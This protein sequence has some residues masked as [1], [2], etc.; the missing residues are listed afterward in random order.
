MRLSCE[1]YK[2]PRAEQK[3]D[4]VPL[5]DVII[6]F[7]NTPIGYVRQ[8]IESVR[9]QTLQ[10]WRAVV[11]NDG[12]DAKSTEALD[13]LVRGL[14]DARV[15]VVTSENRGL[16]AARNLGIESSDSDFIAFLDS[17]DLW[18]PD[19]LRIQFDAMRDH[20]DVDLVHASCDRL[21]GDGQCNIRQVPARDTGLNELTQREACARM[22]RGNFVSGNTVMVRRSAGGEIGFF[23]ATFRSLEDKEMW[24]RWLIAG[25]RFLHLP[26][27]LAVYRIH[28]TNMSKNALHMRQGRMRLVH[29]I[30]TLLG[31]SSASPLAHWPRL[32]REM[33][34]RAN[35]ET[36][37]AYLDSR[38]YVQA[39]RYAMPWHS[40]LSMHSARL[41][42]LAVLG[43]LRIRRSA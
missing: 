11:V 41:V 39:L 12:S 19:K 5:V 17:D 29:K 3:E 4:I 24:S 13:A 6:P 16:S 9:A 14:R 31:G 27:P 8:A 20:P 40:G 10:D 1:T 26:V 25:R 30:D 43:G 15:E 34:F 2:P 18:Y 35:Q 28:A 23:D 38:T 37:E 42:T 21:I 22:L 33:V 32:R 7:Y 36:A